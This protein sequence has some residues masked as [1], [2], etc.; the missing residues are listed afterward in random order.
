MSRIGELENQIRNLISEPR[1]CATIRQNDENWQR[2]CRSLDTL[3]DTEM[4]FEAYSQMPDSNPPGSSYMLVYGFLQALSIQQDAVRDIH[5]ALCVPYKP[6]PVLAEIRDVRNA[7]THPTD[8]RF[9]EF[10]LIAQST[11][12][13]W[14][15]KLFRAA[16]ASDER[17][18]NY[19]SLEELL[20]RQR[21]P[22]ERA[23]EALI[24]ALCKGG[25]EYR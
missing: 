14:G 13:K 19:V 15:F 1:R 20:D 23:L 3:G 9:K 6:D 8:G 21:A 18:S 16:P 10:R 25:M 2:L 17:K 7:V 4:A 5:C 12:S 11:L 22:H 24:E